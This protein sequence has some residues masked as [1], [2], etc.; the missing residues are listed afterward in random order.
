MKSLKLNKAI[1][2]LMTL[3]VIA[4]TTLATPVAVYADDPA[5]V[6]DSS[7]NSGNNGGGGSASLKNLATAADTAIDGVQETIVSIALSLVPL[8]IIIALV[9]MLITHDPKKIKAL[10]SICGTVVVVCALIMIVNG[11]TVVNIIEEFVNT[12]GLK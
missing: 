12:L 11:G 4:T 7:D 1:L 10:V 9:G 5:P 2:Y 6:E 3:L 8:A